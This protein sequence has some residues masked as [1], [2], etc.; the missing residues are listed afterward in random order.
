MHAVTNGVHPSTW[1]SLP[2]ARCTTSNLPGWCH[3]P[4]LLLRADCCFPMPQSGQ[5][6]Q[7]AKQALI[8][9]VQALTGVSLDPDLPI[10]GFAR[11]MTAYKRPDLLFADLRTPQE[12]IARRHPFQIVMA[13][14][15][16][17]LDAAG[18]RLIEALHAYARE[19]AGAIPMAYLPD[20][21]MALAQTLVAGADVWLNTPLPPLE[22]SGTSGMKAAF[23]GVPNF[24]GAR[25]LV[26][27]GLYRR[28]DRMGDWMAL[29][30]PLVTMP[31]HCT[32]SWNRWCC[33]CITVTIRTRCRAGS[34]S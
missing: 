11:R 23:N 12:S 5:A 24:V 9:K 7:E 21:D 10:L 13:G 18:K 3:E 33:R 30:T 26:A 6:H 8:D 27:R 28:G 15:A 31:R 29:S 1:T 25:W 16:H 20:Y 14:K 32:T 17:P 2:F 34:T 22:A 4:E 19:L